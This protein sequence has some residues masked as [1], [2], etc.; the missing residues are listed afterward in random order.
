MPTDTLTAEREAW[1][2]ARMRARVQDGYHNSY[3]VAAVAFWTGYPR[4]YVAD[5]WRRREAIETR[6]RALGGEAS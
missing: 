6:A 3:A 4:A 1:I 2:V 5:C